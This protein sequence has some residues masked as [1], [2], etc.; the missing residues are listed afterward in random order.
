MPPRGRI[1][2]R[3]PTKHSAHQP[4]RPV[5]M[6][7]SP[8]RWSVQTPPPFSRRARAD[9]GLTTPGQDP[10]RWNSARGRRPR[11]RSLA[12]QLQEGHRG[13][14]AVLTATPR[15]RPRRAPLRPHATAATT[16]RPSAASGRTASRAWSVSAVRES[17]PPAAGYR[18]RPA[19]SLSCRVSGGRWCSIARVMVSSRPHSWRPWK[20]WYQRPRDRRATPIE[21]GISPDGFHAGATGVEVAA[22]MPPE[23]CP[24]QST[25]SRS[26]I[27]LHR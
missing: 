6:A 24:A 15:Y 7:P 26:G 18:W 12:R 10:A 8:P 27:D 3:A 14:T 23:C 22:G 21:K 13:L 11:P 20:V 19:V 17:L 2:L 1:W 9:K 25:T 16:A 4:G 5:T